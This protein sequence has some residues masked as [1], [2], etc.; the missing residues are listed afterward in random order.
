[1]AATTISANN[2]LIAYRKEIAREY[3]RENLFSPYI[4]TGITAI[5]RVI[6]DLKKGGEQINIPLVA[7]LTSNGTGVGPLVGNEEA[8]DNYGVR[9]WI[10]WCRNAVRINNAEEQKSSVDLW[11]EA[12]PL[13]SDWGKE[14]QRDE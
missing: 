1:M 2:K 9:F 8:I 6:N 3:V 13:L 4:D 7:R 12:K 14:K 5:I 11:G 10:D